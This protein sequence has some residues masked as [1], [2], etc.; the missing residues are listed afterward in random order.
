MVKTVLLYLMALLYITAGINHFIH[1]AFYLKIMPPY[2]PYHG[3]MV[4]ASGV[5]EIVFGLLLIP[6]TT[7]RVGAWL[8][9]LLL[10][11]IFPANLQMAMDFYR[12]NNPALWIA[13]LRLPLQ[14]VLIGWAWWYTRSKF[15]V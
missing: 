10:I 15:E 5:A 7:R 9:I 11:A 3:L 4:A 12:E 14:L 1:P 6:P 13:V 8:I 2:I